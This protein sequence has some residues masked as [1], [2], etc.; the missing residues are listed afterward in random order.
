MPEPTCNHRN[1]QLIA[2][3]DESEYVECL[4]CGKILDG[5][6]RAAGAAEFNESLSDA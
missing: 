1:V 6:D 4:D 2:R 5:E 3:D